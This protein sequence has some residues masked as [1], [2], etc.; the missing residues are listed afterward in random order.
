MKRFF[1]LIMIVLLNVPAIYA[2]NSTSGTNFWLTFG[3]NADINSN[4][5]DLQ[6][7]IVSGNSPTTGTISFTNLPISHDFTIPAQQVYTYTLSPAEKQAVY[8]TTMGTSNRS[9]HITTHEGK[10]VVIYAL[11]Q[12]STSTDATNILPVT[13]LGNDYYQMSYKTYSTYLDAYAVIAVE[14]NT[15]VYHNGVIVATLN[16]GGVYYRTSATDMTGAHITADKPVAFF[17]LNQSTTIPNGIY[18]ADCLF[19][20]LAPAHTWGKNFF[21]PV[22]DPRFDGYGSTKD[23]VRIVVSQNNT[24]ILQA[25]GSLITNSG[26]Q[27]S[28]TNL[29]AGQFVELEIIQQNR[30]CYIQA[31]K[32]IGVCSYLTG[33]NHNGNGISDPAQAWIPAIEQMITETFVSPFI[34]PSGNNL[35]YHGFLIVTPTATKNNTQL[36]IGGGAFQYLTTNAWMDN[37]AA[38]MSYFTYDASYQTQASYRFINAEGLFVLGYGIG[39]SNSYY[40][41]AGAAM[42]NLSAAFIAN[43]VPFSEMAAHLF[44]EN[45]ITFVAQ[46]DGINSNNGSLRWYIDGSLHSELEDLH[47][48]TRTFAAGEYEIKMEVDFEDGS[49]NNYTSVLNIGAHITVEVEPLEYG[50][51]EGM[52]ECYKV[53]S[54]ATLFANPYHCYVFFNWTDEDDN[55][56]STDNP[57]II[58][59]NGDLNLIAHFQPKGKNAAKAEAA[60]KEKRKKKAEAEE[61]AKNAKNATEET[62]DD[63]DE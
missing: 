63:I 58:P 38:G 50:T 29:Q 46:I 48:W 52:A 33:A 37:S 42:R 35:F 12:Y 57:L 59:V 60:I 17:A 7:R 39:A 28:L 55:E 13:A 53:G 41:L 10:Q 15:H 40:Y 4:T 44:C 34:P 26:G 32:Q 30:G 36:S 49:T 3:Q 47:T 18:G 14:N 23:R 5:V 22:S 6:I 56:I 24:N 21:V 1:H 8:N 27:T 2:Q 62:N 43:E 19:Q 45:E 16:T 61:K 51:I 31:D 20:Q 54:D 11:N 25:G 9:I